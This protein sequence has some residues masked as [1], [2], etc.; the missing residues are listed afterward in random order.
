VKNIKKAQ[1]ERMKELN[2]KKA[3]L[4][5]TEEEPYQDPDLG[6]SPKKPPTDA[7]VNK[8]IKLEKELQ[9]FYR[10]ARLAK[11]TD[12]EIKE[13]AFGPITERLDKVEKAIKQT[14]EELK[15]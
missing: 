7:Q 2:E 10:Q 8:T 13:H 12:R 3:E 15:K 1:T 14:D 6:P 5:D 9:H 11:I 4:I